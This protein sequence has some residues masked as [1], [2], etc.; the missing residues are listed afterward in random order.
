M[1]SVLTL[2]FLAGVALVVS[3]VAARRQP[4]WRVIAAQAGLPAPTSPFHT[5]AVRVL[6]AI[7]GSA[8]VRPWG[9]DRALRHLASR[10]ELVGGLRAARLRQVRA[11]VALLCLVVAWGGL[12]QATH[13]GSSPAMAVVLLAIA[14]I[15]GAGWWVT[16]TLSAS[17][18][19]R[20]MA[21]DAQLPAVL[22]LLSFA[23][24]AGEGMAAAIRRVEGQVQ[25]ALP[26]V[27]RY[28]SIQV[29]AGA[30]LAAVL[31]DQAART[32]SVPLARAVH[33]I[34][35]ATERG[36]P[37]ADVLRAQAADSRAE[38]LRQM[39]EIAGRKEAAMML[40]VVFLILPVIVVVAVYPGMVSFQLW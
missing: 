35:V 10:A 37:L 1:T 3:W 2:T 24:A 39:L 18:R 15:P 13:P 8:L 19:K 7:D 40:P 36:T 38:H 11:T 34:N 6:R 5:A 4:M 29:A 27:L 30:P 28:V 23:V 22:E 31:T 16:A 32:G 9:S 33:A 14:A 12:R 25:G 21:L 26:D 17:A 20:T